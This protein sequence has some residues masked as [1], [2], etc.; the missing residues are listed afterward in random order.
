MEPN[1]VAEKMSQTLSSGNACTVYYMYI[2]LN[3]F[4]TTCTLPCTE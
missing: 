1:K 3:M 2:K 4:I